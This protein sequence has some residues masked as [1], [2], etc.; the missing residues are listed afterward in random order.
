M[1]LSLAQIKMSADMA[2]NYQ[3]SIDKIKEAASGDADII[4]FPE[5]QFCKFFPQ[6]P[7]LD[8]KHFAQMVDDP[9][10]KQ[11]RQ[12]CRDLNIVIIPNI[13]LR[14]NDKYY[15]ASIV[16]D[17]DGEILGISK[18]VHIARTKHFYE[19]DYYTPSDTGFKIY[20]TKKGKI[21]IVICFDRHYPESIRK[22]AASGAD[23]VLIPTANTKSEPMELFAWEMRVAAYQNNIFI[24]MCNRCGK[25]DEMDFSGESI[26]C[27]PNGNVIY[28]A[29]Y[30]EE[31]IIKD[32]DIKG[33]DKIR[34][35]KPYL[36]LLR[37]E[38]Y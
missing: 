5:L 15:D 34:N 1:K 9:K 30:D 23:I 3:K 16:I 37:H 10:I 33:I 11:M 22:C 6:F 13:Y 31:L 20:N 19:Q 7:N 24:A 4:L 26:I 18:M 25:E 8:V 21:G 32:I 2:D 29:G 35:S 12:L 28:K 38:F 17:S 27:D 36:N 14:E